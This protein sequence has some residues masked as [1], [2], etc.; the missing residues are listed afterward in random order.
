MINPLMIL[1]HLKSNW[2]LYA[3]VLCILTSYSF[4]YYKAKESFDKKM[5]EYKI[6]KLEKIVEVNEAMSKYFTE[7]KVTQDYTVRKLQEI[8]LGLNT[9]VFVTKDCT[10]NE[11]FIK[12]WN[13]INSAHSQPR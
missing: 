4:G 7:Y 11:D 5:Q 9:K 2:K 8:K 1:N 12:L 13:S 10:P 3:F 6:E